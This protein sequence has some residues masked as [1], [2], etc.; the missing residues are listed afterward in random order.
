MGDLTQLETRELITSIE[1][2]LASAHRTLAEAVYKLAYNR[3]DDDLIE[4]K[5]HLDDRISLLSSALTSARHV[6]NHAAMRRCVDAIQAH[7]ESTRGK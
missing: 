4:R 5:R 7:I 1:D 3:N 2:D 6:E